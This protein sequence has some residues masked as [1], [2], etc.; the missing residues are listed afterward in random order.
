[1]AS[2]ESNIKVDAYSS[3]AANG[4][5]VD[6]SELFPRTDEAFDSSP[7]SEKLR[8]A[9]PPAD[10]GR[11]AWLFLAGCFLVEGLV[12]SECRQSLINEKPC[13]F[14]LFANFRYKFSLI[15]NY[16]PRSPILF[17]CLR[18]LL[19]YSPAFFREPA[20]SC[21]RWYYSICHSPS[22]RLTLVTY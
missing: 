8:S 19:L 22:D 15:R 20:Q 3:V 6:S 2:P 10:H 13:D 16:L 7:N 9:V 4:P 1:M 14:A 11:A 12:W 21:R 17:R 18:A 5:T